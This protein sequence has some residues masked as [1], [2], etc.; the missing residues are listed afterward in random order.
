[1][2]TPNALMQGIINEVYLI[3]KRPDLI[4]ETQAAVA[5]A[6]MKLHALDVFNQD[7][8]S[9]VLNSGT[10][11]ALPVQTDYHYSIDLS[12]FTRLRNIAYVRDYASPLTGSETEY[13]A[14]SPMNIFDEYQLERYNYFY[15]AGTALKLRSSKQLSSIQIGYFQFPIVDGATYASWIASVYPQAIQD[16]AAATIFRSI[17][18]DEEFQRYTAINLENSATLKA[19]G[20]TSSVY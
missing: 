6:T 2:S 12:S 10:T 9:V 5:R 1:M 14:L 20:S 11:P 7:L 13:E 18:K 4:S 3:T 15:R 16:E 8:T 19:M 17:G